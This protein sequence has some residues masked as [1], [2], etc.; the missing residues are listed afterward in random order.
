[1]A[2]KRFAAKLE[3]SLESKSISALLL[4]ALILDFLIR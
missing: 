3:G 4:T 1:M 2:I